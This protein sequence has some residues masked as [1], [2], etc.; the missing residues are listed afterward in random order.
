MA[1]IR[2][3]QQVFTKPIGVTRM[4]TG[5][6]ELW[7]TVKQGA[8]RI[9]SLA[10]Q[11]NQILAE[12]AG[13]EAGLDLDVSQ[14]NGINPET[15][16]SEPLSAPKGF[17]SIAR[18]AYEKVVDARFMDDAQDRLKLKAKELGSKYSRSPEEFSRQMSNFIAETAEKTASG[19]YKS[20][21]VESGQ[22]FLSDMQ[23]NLI[24]QQRSRA[25]ARETDF[26]NYRAFQYGE[27]IGE[28]A[29]NGDFVKAARAY[30]QGRANA[31]RIETAGM[32]GKK[33]TELHKQNY[34]SSFAKGAVEHII[35]SL[36]NDVSRRNFLLYLE[37]GQTNWLR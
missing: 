36:T 28:L 21:I 16:M 37:T 11:E 35:T 24:D 6:A 31:E 4:N 12:E 13:R 32:N 26:A 8:D 20:T 2:Q 1:V 29:A 25:R 15:G 23:I 27:K 33:E 9:S 30:V 22:K 19:K 3:R 5:E 34:A 7:Q 10:F 17:G 14:I 18:R